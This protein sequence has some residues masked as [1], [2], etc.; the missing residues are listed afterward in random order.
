[1]SNSANARPRKSS[2][3]DCCMIVSAEIFP[4]KN[5]KNPMNSTKMTAILRKTGES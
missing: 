1:M 2:G 5:E 3:I 4:T